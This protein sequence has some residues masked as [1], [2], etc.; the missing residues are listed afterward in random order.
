[1]AIKKSM[2]TIMN[3]NAQ[4]V[5]KDF[6]YSI[7]LDLILSILHKLFENKRSKAK[8]PCFHQNF[9]WKK[10][11]TKAFMSEIVKSAQYSILTHHEIWSKLP[12][13]N[14]CIQL[15]PCQTTAPQSYNC[16]PQFVPGPMASTYYYHYYNISVTVAFWVSIMTNVRNPWG[17]HSS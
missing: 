12:L 14:N 4:V 3:Y 8:C 9:S 6:F 16:F 11:N 13:S 10:N 1:M 5:L 2:I 15:H 7:K 17:F